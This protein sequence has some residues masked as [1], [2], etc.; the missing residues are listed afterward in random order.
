MGAGRKRKSAA[1]KMLEGNPGKRPIEIVD[2][3]TGQEL[4]R[5]PP[6][7]LSARGKMVYTTVFEWLEKVGCLKGILPAHLEEYAHCK[8]RWHECEQQN[9]RVGLIVKDNKGN[10]APS[11]FVALSN[12]YLRQANDAWAKIYAVVR[13]SKLQEWDSKSPNDDVMERLLSRRP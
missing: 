12:N 4:P 7:W 13:E 1:E 9:E 11:P 8:A 2:F 3:E 10:P 6:D 5:T